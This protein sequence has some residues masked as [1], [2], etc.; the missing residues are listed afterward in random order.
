[1]KLIYMMGKSSSGKDTIYNILKKKMK[2]NTYIMYTTR[3][4]REGE[5]N[6][7]TYNFITTNEM[8]KYIEGK[9]EQQVIEYRTYKTVK[10]PWTYATINDKQFKTDNDMLMVG[11]LESYMKIKE[12]FGGNVDIQILPIYIEVPDNIRLKRAIEREENEKKPNY[13]ELCR[14]FLADSKDFSEVNLKHA[15][16]NKRFSNINLNDCVKQII[17]YIDSE[18]I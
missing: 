12:C 9:K 7:E 4:M 14:R 13:A 17:D 5:K 8:K 3:P 16:I 6:G 1:M 15:E 2:I 11:T 18:N 10:G